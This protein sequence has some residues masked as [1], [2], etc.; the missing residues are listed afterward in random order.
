MFLVFAGVISG[1]LLL[2]TVARAFYYLA[3]RRG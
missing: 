3:G 1:V 2:I